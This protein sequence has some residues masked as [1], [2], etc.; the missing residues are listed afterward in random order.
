MKICSVDGCE[1]RSRRN[2]MCP[3]HASRMYRNGSL[4]TVKQ[5]PG[6][7]YDWLMNF[8]NSGNFPD[9]ECVFWPFKLNSKGY[10]HIKHNGVRVY[11]HQIACNFYHGEKPE[12]KPLV[13]HLCHKGHLGC[14]NPKHLRWGTYSENTFDYLADTGATQGEKSG[15]SKLTEEQVLEI[16]ELVRSGKMQKK[17]AKDYGVT[18]S[19][20]SRIWLGKSWAHLTKI[21]KRE[22]RRRKG[23]A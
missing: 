5:P 1:T 9:E 8:L 16:V 3:K 12:G 17:I 6:E 20:V 21:P 23:G 19:T 7:A 4:E 22:V 10:A 2:G 13:R 14:V 15:M 18:Q 11:G